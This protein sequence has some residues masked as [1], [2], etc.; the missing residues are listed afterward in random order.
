[1]ESNRYVDIR[2]CVFIRSIWVIENGLK[3]KTCRTWARLRIKRKRF[4][5]MEIVL[6]KKI[7]IGFYKYGCWIKIEMTIVVIAP[8]IKAKMEMNINSKHSN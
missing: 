8:E 4:F 1:M 7:I 5:C 3:W 6:K 2:R